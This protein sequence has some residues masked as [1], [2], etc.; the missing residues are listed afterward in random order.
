MVTLIQRSEQL[1]WTI[2]ACSHARPKYLSPESEPQYT[3]GDP[4]LS[5]DLRWSHDFFLTARGEKGPVLNTG[6]DAFNLTNHVNYFTYVGALTS[7]FFGQPVS[8]YP[9]RRLQWGLRFTF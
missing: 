8:A 2:A 4:Y 7:P 3:D 6:V 5:L 9:S 1:G